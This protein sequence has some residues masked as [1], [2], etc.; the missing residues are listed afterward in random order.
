MPLTDAACRGAK[1]DPS[2]KPRKLPDG[3]G[4]LLFVSPSGG[5]LWRMRYR[6]EGKEKVLSFGAYPDVKLADARALRA[7]PIRINPLR[8]V[9]RAGTLQPSA[10]VK[11]DTRCIWKMQCLILHKVGELTDRA[12]CRQCQAMMKSPR[13]STFRRL[14]K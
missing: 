12:R 4:L 1:P 10:G 2:G 11:R 13:A 6:F 9:A 3:G 5:R 8:R 14:A 7:K